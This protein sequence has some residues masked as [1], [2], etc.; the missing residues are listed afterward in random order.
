[1]DELLVGEY[2]L[3]RV[4]ELG[5]ESIFGVPGGTTISSSTGLAFS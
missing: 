4:K 1:M 3:K 5:I 2:L